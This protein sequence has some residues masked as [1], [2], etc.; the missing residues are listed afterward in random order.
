MSNKFQELK[1]IVIFNNRENIDHKK[2][3][4]FIL[5]IIISI[6]ICLYFIATQKLQ[7]VGYNR[8]TAVDY[9]YC[10]GIMFYYFDNIYTFTPVTAPASSP[11][12]WWNSK[13]PTSKNIYPTFTPTTS[14]PTL[15]PTA[16]PT[17]D[18]PKYD[19]SIFLSLPQLGLHGWIHFV[20]YKNGFIVGIFITYLVAYIVL[21]LL[22]R[23]PKVF[24]WFILFTLC[25]SWL[26]LSIICFIYGDIVF[27]IIFTLFFILNGSLNLIFFNTINK[28]MTYI[29]VVFMFL[30]NNIQII[31]TIFLIGLIYLFYFTLN[32][33]S[34]IY[35]FLSWKDDNYCYKSFVE[36][37]INKLMAIYLNVILFLVSLFVI[38]LKKNYINM[39]VSHVCYGGEFN[40]KINLTII[41]TCFT[42]SF[43][44]IVN[45][46]IICCFVDKIIDNAK[47]LIS[48]LDIS[49]LIFKF[50]FSINRDELIQY[51][52]FTFLAHSI[53]GKKLDSLT[54]ITR[55]ILKTNFKNR[56][57]NKY[58]LKNIIDMCL[59]VIFMFTF[60][61]LLILDNGAL[62][63][64]G[65]QIFI[66][67][68]LFVLLYIA[69]RPIIMIFVLTT[70][71]V[72]DE[73]EYI[74]FYITIAICICVIV[75][76][77]RY[78]NYVIIDILYCI[79]FSYAVFKFNNTDIENQHIYFTMIKDF[80]DFEDFENDDN[81]TST[82]TNNNVMVTFQNT[83]PVHD[84]SMQNMIN[85]NN[86]SNQQM[87]NTMNQQIV[88]PT[89][90]PKIITNQITKAEQLEKINKLKNEG[91]ITEDEYKQL[92]LD[93]L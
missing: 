43:G 46:S 69:V 57:F 53:N 18:F 26:I 60:L 12:G 7:I 36:T 45:S 85:Q 56:I 41:H 91:A 71:L 87:I 30:K 73:Y 4:V 77:F 35:S 81:T 44:S 39:V 21:F 8:V 19:N 40:N 64:V 33:Y 58:G 52:S 68:F 25:L 90:V 79:F 3:I 11:I 24:I 76:I 49:G 48:Y 75:N 2:G 74:H 92:K 78:V 13:A 31:F 5:N 1:P 32:F 27:G 10:N 38:Y 50:I 17:F 86:P 20:E 37:T 63:W 23:F 70:L 62:F 55:K 67:I 82:A 72:I 22:L 84:V 34:M 54:D 28:Q 6:V 16:H 9:S 83:L 42:T 51:S 15:T 80:E 65:I 14:S 29:H 61:T 59:L 47:N 66:F 88:Q 93:I 89:P